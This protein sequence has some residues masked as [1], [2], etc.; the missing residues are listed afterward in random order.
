MSVTIISRVPVRIIPFT[1][2]GMTIFSYT[3]HD[4][5]GLGMRLGEYSVMQQKSDRDTN[6]DERKPLLNS[7]IDY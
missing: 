2:S 1:I 7:N 5:V 6:I 3:M 4:F